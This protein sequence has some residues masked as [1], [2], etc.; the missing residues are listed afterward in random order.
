[1]DITVTIYYNVGADVSK[2]QKLQEELNKV[3][4]LAELTPNED[5]I[6]HMLSHSYFHETFRT[7]KRKAK[8][9]AEKAKKVSGVDNVILTI[10][11]KTIH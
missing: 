11:G 2:A 10:D 7:T 1:M 6:K 5:N 3:A 8:N 4:K 9:F